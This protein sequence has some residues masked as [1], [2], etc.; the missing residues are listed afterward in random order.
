LPRSVTA[1]AGDAG[2]VVLG[3]IQIRIGARKS[4]IEISGVTFQAARNDGAIEISGAITVTG[5][6]EPVVENSGVADRKL[7]KF[8]ITPEEI[9]LP[10]AA[11]TDDQFEAFRACAGGRGRHGP[12]PRGIG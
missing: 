1:F 5:T 6:V 7:E 4:G 3:V 8:V 11:R 12:L 10:F 2:D 9:V